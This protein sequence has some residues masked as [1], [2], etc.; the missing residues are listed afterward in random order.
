MRKLIWSNTFVK[1][2][3]KVIRKHPDLSHDV[4]VTLELLIHDPFSPQ[5]RTHKLK[6]RLQNC[7][8]CSIGYDMRIVFEFLKSEAGED[9]IFLV[10][11]GTH[12]E[13]Y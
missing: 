5:L 9:N 7:W 8:A 12:D 1:S 6:G 11:I 3:K 2:V 10:D 4:E 13:I